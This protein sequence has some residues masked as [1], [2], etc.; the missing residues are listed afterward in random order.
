MQ[1]IMIAGLSLGLVLAVVG[2][3]DFFIGRPISTFVSSFVNRTLRTRVVSAGIVL[4]GIFV[5]AFLLG[6]VGALWGKIG[7]GTATILGN[8]E[9]GEELVSN[10]CLVDYVRYSGIEGEDADIVT[11]TTLTSDDANPDRYFLD[12]YNESS[13][14]NTGQDLT[15]NFS[16]WLKE[17]PVT[18][19]EC[20][21]KLYMV[22]PT[23]KSQIS[24]SDSTTIYTLID[25]SLG[26]SD[27]AGVNPGNRVDGIVWTQN[28]YLADST[29]E[30]SSSDDAEITAVNFGAGE[31][32]NGLGFSFDLNSAGYAQIKKNNQMNIYIM[33]Q[34]GA[35]PSSSDPVVYTLTLRKGVLG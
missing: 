5:F 23:F 29:A 28:T 30:A 27:I 33:Q 19:S 1:D 17:A 3:I 15:G 13:W 18:G 11:N 9:N 22:G 8:G 35:V 32:K 12:T 14:I 24:T 6:G 31:V 16:V 10:D 7:L 34:V 25:E 2:V 21:A 26:A 4:I 20:N